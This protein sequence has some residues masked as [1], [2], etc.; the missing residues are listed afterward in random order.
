MEHRADKIVIGTLCL[1]NIEAETNRAE[2]GYEMLPSYQGKGYMQE[3]IIPVIEYG[4]KGMG[5]DSISAI[6]HKDNQKS[7]VL[8][9]RN[10]FTLDESIKVEDGPDLGCYILRCAT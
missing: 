5:L 6:I 9:E 2:I 4:F 1:W 8:A 10:G 3:A 7:I